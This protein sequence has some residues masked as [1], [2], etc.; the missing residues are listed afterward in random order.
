MRVY[1]VRDDLGIGRY[2][3]TRARR[4]SPTA[5]RCRLSVYLTLG[6]AQSG[7]EALGQN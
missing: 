7:A 3:R 4:Q 6:L 1:I 5:T 2:G